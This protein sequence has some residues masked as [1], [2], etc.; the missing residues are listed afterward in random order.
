M[1]V[2]SVKQTMAREKKKKIIRDKLKDKMIND[3]WTVFET[4]QEKEDR[5]K[6]SIMKE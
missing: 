6:R 1:L 4:E 3:N 5:K 2:R